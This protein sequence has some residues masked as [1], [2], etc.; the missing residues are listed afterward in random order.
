MR[1]TRLWTI[2]L[3]PDMSDFAEEVARREQRTKSELIREAL[4]HYL[5]QRHQP[6]A[7]GAGER[8]A[9]AAEL[10]EVYLRRH[11]ARQPGEAELR[12]RF[13]GVRQLHER[14]RLLAA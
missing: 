11:A 12:R 14:L 4:R 7:L 13:R 8:L 3:P 10:A 2:S 6:L 5:A 1:T 9:R